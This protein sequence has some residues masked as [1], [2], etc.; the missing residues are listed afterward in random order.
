VFQGL[1]AAGG[2]ALVLLFIHGMVPKNEWPLYS[3]FMAATISIAN[4]AGPLV[5]GA[6]SE[7]NTWRWVFLLK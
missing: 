5:G 1:G 4:L 3:S 7:P 6:L 2:F